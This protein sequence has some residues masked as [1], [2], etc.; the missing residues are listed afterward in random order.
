MLNR[1]L[2]LL[3]N[4]FIRFNCFHLKLEESV[5]TNITFLIIFVHRLMESHPP[6]TH[7][8]QQFAQKFQDTMGILDAIE[9]VSI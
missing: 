2:D 9:V 1:V 3:C 4:R 5:N 7:E 6:A 8:Y